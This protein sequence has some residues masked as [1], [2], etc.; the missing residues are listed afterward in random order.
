MV[1]SVLSSV[2]GA[3]TGGCES[4]AGRRAGDSAPTRAARL[5]WLLLR[6]RGGMVAML[7]L[8]V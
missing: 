8:T 3:G 5:L 2:L 7:V 1:S 6:C 4:C